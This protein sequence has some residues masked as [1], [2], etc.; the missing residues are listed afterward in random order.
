MRPIGSRESDAILG[1][2]RQVALAGGRPLSHADTASLIAA[3]HWLLRRDQPFD[4][5]TLPGIGPDDLVRSLKGERTLG[6]EAVKYLA[7]M[8]LVDGVLD[9]DKIRHV[10]DYARALDVE[11]DYLTELVEAASGHMAWVVADMTRK[12]FDSVLSHPSTGLDPA[13]WIMPYAGDKADPALVA[14][15]EALA[16]LPDNSFGKSLWQFNKDNGYA[17]P[18]DPKALNAGFATPHDST[19]VISG[20]DTSYRGEILVST[21]TAGMH[22]INPMAGHILPVIFNGHLGVKF[23]DVATPG[24]GGLDPNEFWHAW[25]RGQEMTMDLFAPDWDVWQWVEHDLSTLRRD[26]NVTPPGHPAA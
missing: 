6:Q 18:G 14:R 13:A 16:R 22:P 15:Y 12:N 21:F 2:M 7:I 25:A 19:H 11:A 9:H 24:Q 3:G 23:N 10:L 20:Y 5:G 17:F 1:A 4:V 8:A 26:W